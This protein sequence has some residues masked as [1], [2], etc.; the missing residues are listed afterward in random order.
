MFMIVDIVVEITAPF[1][2]CLLAYPLARRIFESKEQNFGNTLITSFVFSLMFIMLLP[3]SIGI[4]FNGGFRITSWVI[5]LIGIFSIILNIKTFIGQAK[6]SL[7]NFRN[8]ISRKELFNIIFVMA[9]IGFSIKY[10]YYLLIKAVIDWDATAS[11]LPYAKAISLAD[12]VPLTAFDYS[13]FTKP[14]GISFLYSW[15]YSLGSSISAENFRL[16][17]LSFTLI[18]ILLIYLVAKEVYSNSLAKLTVM[19]Y[20]FLP[21]HDS[22][23][24]YC[25][26]YPDI[27][28][29]SLIISVF[30]FLYKYVKTLEI[31]FCLISGVA[32]GLSMMLKAQT[33]LY[34]IAI[35]LVFI[36][37]FRRKSIRIAA[38]FAASFVFLIFLIFSASASTPILT[39]FTYES[40]LIFSIIAVMLISIAFI[41]EAQHKTI[42]YL[43]SD[44][45]PLK[46]LF[47]FL[48]S[49]SIAL[50]WYLR[51]YFLMGTF[52]WL[53]SIKEPNLQWAIG[54][55]SGMA[56]KTPSQPQTFIF[57]IALTLLV[58]PILGSIW[59]IPK[60]IGIVKLKENQ[61]ILLVHIWVLGFF[62]A[63]FLYVFNIIMTSS[64]VL[65]PRDLIPLAP[66]FSIYSALGLQI[67]AKRFWKVQQDLI[68]LSLLLF[69]GFIS[70]VQSLLIFY[71][72]T[73]FLADICKEIT[74]LSLT[75]WKLLA[76]GPPEVVLN[77]LLFGLFISS[78]L[79]VLFIGKECIVYVFYKKKMI[80]VIPNSL[81]TFGTWKR[82]V[83][84]II[85][86]IAFLALQIVP[87]VSLTYEYGNGDILSFKGNQEIML[88]NGLYTDILTYLRNNTNNGDIILTIGTGNTGLQYKLDSVKFIDLTFPD[89]LASVRSLIEGNNTNNIVTI[90]HN[91]HVRYFLFSTNSEY[92]SSFVAWLFDKSHLLNT[93][94][95]PKFS[96]IKLRSGGWI[97]LEITNEDSD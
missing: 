18:T 89:N 61:Q 5:Y 75:T 22:I 3:Y 1:V 90:L 41:I 40:F 92:G 50:V 58:H 44:F 33:A 46:G 83:V 57:L 62:L 86:S 31:K 74:K 84:C 2:I 23:L 8:F 66:F 88:Y 82:A 21:L 55:L 19:I 95:D 60:I 65:N 7:K 79:I 53:S 77:W 70:L 12:T 52:I 63:Y 35:L 71:H 39:I 67:I 4:I 76:H 6:I 15:I 64:F 38:P 59:I 9:L 43:K 26:Y 73:H 34:F 42:K 54:I 25:S 30:F 68:V 37:F 45:E 32:F 29:Y 24:Y 13:R 51:N 16:V 14:M 20:I 17:P 93:I 81:K 91:L 49:S 96:T 85:I 48:V 11:Y 80:T 36:P 10:T 28:F 94:L 78:F 72:P 47:I 69:L 56:S 87:Y 97:L 27:A